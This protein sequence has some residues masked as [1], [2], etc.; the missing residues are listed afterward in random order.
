MNNPTY[1]VLRE[2]IKGHQVLVLELHLTGNFPP[3]II[4]VLDNN[5][6]CVTP[7]L[8]KLFFNLS[9][10]SFP[11]V[12]RKLWLFNESEMSILTNYIRNG[13]IQKNIFVCNIYM[14]YE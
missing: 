13:L 12:G 2:S 11:V 14:N 1:T 5:H 9:C 6:K 10:V 8:K 3:Y 7:V 4:K